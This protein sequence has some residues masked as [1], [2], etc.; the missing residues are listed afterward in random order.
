VTRPDQEPDADLAQ[1]VFEELGRLSFAEH[2][3]E[4]FLQQVTDAAARVLPGRPLASVTVIRKRGPSTAAASDPLAVAL[5]EVQY[6]AGDGPCV[7]AATTGRPAEVP[8]TA[9]ERRGTALAA[10]AAEHGFGSVLS[11][12][13]PAHEQLSAGLNIY[14]PRPHATDEHTRALV[15]RF[16]AYAAVPVSNMYLYRSAVERAEHLQV[17]LDSR[18]VI[19]QAKGVLMERFKLTPDQAFQALARISM[20]HNVRVREVAQRFVES[21]ELPGH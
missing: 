7:E 10:T 13:L 9:A 19:D 16:A 1:S 12:P 11:H 8:D 4:S 14:S 18:I 5:D 15:A 21:G 2:S 17:A 6:R 20:E 3:L